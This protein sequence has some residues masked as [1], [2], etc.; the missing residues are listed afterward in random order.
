MLFRSLAAG[1]GTE[2]YL[3]TEGD[4]EQ[5]ALSAA[6]TPAYVILGRLADR[7]ALHLLNEGWTPKV[8]Q[9]VAGLIEGTGFSMLDVRTYWDL[10][11]EM[12]KDDPD[13]DAI[14]EN[15]KTIVGTAFGFGIVRGLRPSQT[16]RIRGSHNPAMERA[17]EDFGAMYEQLASPIRALGDAGWIPGPAPKGKGA[18]FRLPAYGDLTVRMRADG[19][20]VEPSKKL[21]KQMGVDA[22]EHRGQNAIDLMDRIRTETLAS[23]IN[24]RAAGLQEYTWEDVGRGIWWSP[25]QDVYVTNRSGS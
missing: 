3:A 18:V 17:L 6:M 15:L 20:A 25:Q 10:V 7:S 1:F 16:A 22:K 9:S 5:A 19:L 4:A 12:A 13:M 24:T 11:S 8:A 2:T 23:G 14:K 21:A